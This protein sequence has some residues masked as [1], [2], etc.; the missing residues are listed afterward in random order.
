MPLTNKEI[1]DI[2]RKYKAENSPALSK[3]RRHELIQFGM[4]VRLLKEGDL[5][6]R[7]LEIYLGH[8]PPTQKKVTRK[9]VPKESKK[10]AEE[11]NEIYY[12]ITKLSINKKIVNNEEIPFVFKALPVAIETIGSNNFVLEVKED[13]KIVGNISE[14]SD[15]ASKDDIKNIQPLLFH[16]RS[17]CGV[18]RETTYIF[19]FEYKGKSH[20][21]NIRVDKTNPDYPNFDYSI[22]FE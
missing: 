15:Q 22:W 21:F 4:K 14:D 11:K 5:S 20:K 8:R 6:R 7:D 2:L 3:M 13:G 9:P 19:S 10:E 16:V 18:T 12:P 1:K 17:L